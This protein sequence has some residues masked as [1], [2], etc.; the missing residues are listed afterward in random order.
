MGQQAAVVLQL[1][2][3][4]PS[5][6]VYADHILLGTA[7]ERF[8]SMGEGEHEIRL[9]AADQFSWSIPP[10]VTRIDSGIAGDTIAVRLD[11]PYYY[12]LES[13]P[14]DA[15][16]DLRDGLVVRPLGFTPSTVESATPLTGVLDI[17]LA[18]FKTESIVPGAELWNL[19]VIRLEPLEETGDVSRFALSPPPSRRRWIDYAAIGTALVAGG[20]AVHFKFKADRRYDRYVETGDPTL[21]PTIKRYD[22]YSGVALGVMQAGA[23]LFA[24]RLILR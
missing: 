23:G 14:F 18:G 20:V 13:T 19:H 8:F 2:T 11:F 4:A 15:E 1:E 10:V 24:V 12:R 22:T 21:R 9:V 3:N 6:R 17:R 5:A 16:V 7:S